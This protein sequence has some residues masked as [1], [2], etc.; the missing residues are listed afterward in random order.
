MNKPGKLIVLRGPSGAGKSTVAKML[1]ERTA[2]KSA[3]IE[4]DYYRHVILNNPHSDLEVARHIQFASMRAAL[5]QGCDVIA[6]GIMSMGKYKKFFDEL[7]QSHPTE[8]YFFYF[9]VSFEETTR[10]HS[11]RSKSQDFT[12]QE[13]REWYDRASPTGYPNEHIIPEHCSAEQSL[14]LI[15][16]VANLALQ[17]T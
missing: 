4:Q 15:T 10:R 13:M 3:L 2:K 14:K 17:Q 16:H 5:E 1:H 12:A 6:E 7:L 8:N 9:D 11:T